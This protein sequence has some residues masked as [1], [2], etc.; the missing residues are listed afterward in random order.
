V[1][2]SVTNE[3]LKQRIVVTAAAIAAVLAP[4][5]GTLQSFINALTGASIRDGAE[6]ATR[7]APR[8]F[9]L[10][11][12]SDDAHR[13]GHPAASD[14]LELATAE[15]AAAAMGKGRW[16]GGHQE[17][18]TSMEEAM[19]APDVQAV[20]DV[21]KEY[22]VKRHETVLR[23]INA[24]AGTRYE[25]RTVSQTRC[26]TAEHR[27]GRG[28]IAEFNL[29]HHCGDVQRIVQI[30]SAKIRLED[31]LSLATFLCEPDHPCVS[32]GEHVD[33][34]LNSAGG[35]YINFYAAVT[36]PAGLV[37]VVL[38]SGTTGLKTGYTV[39]LL[40]SPFACGCA[41]AWRRAR[42]WPCALARSGVASARAL[43]RRARHA[44]RA[45]HTWA[46]T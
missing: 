29:A 36:G 2:A 31:A 5:A 22:G 6:M 30:D 3:R 44:G 1:L 15:K 45:L 4:A 32:G 42:P 46:R 9:E 26:L 40:H 33:P 39:S 41:P 18:Y 14:R 8:F 37:C 10:G 23:A 20:Y 25:L 35:G 11:S 13:S 12:V 24:K 43:P 16:V 38:V 19:T 34:R 27:L 7:W 28:E 21:L 17:P